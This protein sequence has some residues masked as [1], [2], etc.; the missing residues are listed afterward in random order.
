[1]NHSTELK[2]GVNKTSLFQRVIRVIIYGIGGSVGSR[3]LMVLSGVIISRILGK[4]YYGQFSMVNSTVTLFIT[5][6]GVGISSTLT[7]YVAL[8]KD[9]TV[10][11]GNVVGTLSRVVIIFSVLISGIMLLFAR[12]L[13]ILVC[14]TV[15]LKNYF[16]ITSITIFFSAIAAVQQSIILGM[17]KYKVSA[18]IELIRCSIYL[19]LASI[20]SVFASIYGAI[21]SL[22]IS[23]II[24]FLLMYFENKKE[25]RRLDMVLNYKFTEEIKEIIW[26]FTVPAFIASLFVI[27][28]NWINNAILTRQVGFGELAIFSV[29]VQWMTIITYIPSQLGQVRPIYTDLFAKGNFKDLKILF[30]NITLSSI[31]IVFPIVVFMMIFGRN[32]LSFYGDGYGNGYN[33]FVIMMVTALLITIQSQ[34]GSLLQALGKMWTGFWLNLIWSI[35]V[36]GIFYYFRELGSLGY[37]ISYC[38]AYG[39]HMIL[40]YIVIFNLWK[41]GNNNEGT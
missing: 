37:S 20:L 33:T 23:H 13:S 14:G 30:R 38:I 26:K 12:E 1:M 21:F 16:M 4:E 5:F 28:V 8:Y 32:V 11:L 2:L 36:V 34:V 24:Q 15:I 27:P 18:K 31:G 40:S 9:N 19:V 7:R 35:L 3:A 10:K 39:V 6:S 25:Y 17:E 29:S 41:R 22:L